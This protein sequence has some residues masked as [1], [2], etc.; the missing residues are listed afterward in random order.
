[1]NL[2]NQNF[3]ARWPKCYRAVLAGRPAAGTTAL[4]NFLTGLNVCSAKSD[5]FIVVK[6][7]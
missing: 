2:W 7:M 5:Y 4:K 6:T 1:M 3:L